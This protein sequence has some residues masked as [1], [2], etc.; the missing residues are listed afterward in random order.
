[1]EQIKEE[2]FI[3]IS[4]KI[5]ISII[6]SVVFVFAA[7]FGLLERQIIRLE[8]RLDNKSGEI[9][10][11]KTEDIPDLEKKD[12]ILEYK[13]LMILRLIDGNVIITT[14]EYTPT[15]P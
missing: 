9:Y 12:I 1:M 4:V 14:D 8:N 10:L 7:T 6:V 13:Q 5:A 2:S 3:K 15:T 11:L